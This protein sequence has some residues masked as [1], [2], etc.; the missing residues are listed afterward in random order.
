MR[1]SRQGC[2]CRTRLSCYIKQMK[3]MLVQ[4]QCETQGQL[5][6]R[7]RRRA[8]ATYEEYLW[9][10]LSYPIHRKIATNQVIRK[11]IEKKFIANHPRWWYFT[12]SR[13]G[14]G[15]ASQG[16]QQ[17]FDDSTRWTQSGFEYAQTQIPDSQPQPPSYYI[18]TP[19]IF[20]NDE[21]EAISDIVIKDARPTKPKRHT[22]SIKGAFG[23]MGCEEGQNS[24]YQSTWKR[25]DAILLHTQDIASLC[26]WILSPWRPNLD[27]L[28]CRRTTILHTNLNLHGITRGDI[29]VN[30]RFLITS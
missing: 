6:G 25:Y 28:R 26:D 29:N 9:L 27:V 18:R 3:G 2:V 13:A 23:E 14:G 1:C 19:L 10:Q 24:G 15:Y 4:M 22:R 8:T 17:A 5:Q 7:A 30:M 11:E 12:R 16:R 20:Y 21:T